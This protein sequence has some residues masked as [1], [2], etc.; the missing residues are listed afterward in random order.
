[1]EEDLRVLAFTLVQ[2]K[3][4]RMIEINEAEREKI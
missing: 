4:D 2:E 3:K 1:M